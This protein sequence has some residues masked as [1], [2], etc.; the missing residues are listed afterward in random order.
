MMETGMLDGHCILVV[1]DEYLIAS[2]MTME[3][4][5]AGARVV[6]PVSDVTGGFSIIGSGRD[7]VDCAVLDVNLHGATVF[8]VADRLSGLN[9]PY[10]FLTGYHCDT[11]PERFKDVPCL[12]KP[13]DEQE[14]I[15]LLAAMPFRHG[16]CSSFRGHVRLGSE[17]EL[18]GLYAGKR[19]L[20]VEDEYFL[21]DE[22]RRKLVDLGAIV[23]GPVA[24]VEDALDLIEANA[25]DA[26]ILDVHLGDEFVFPVAERL[27]ELDVSFVFATGYDPSFIP[28]EF[29]GFS[30]C[31]KPTELGK[32]ANALWGNRNEK[33]Q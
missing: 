14:L 3:L 11:M 5:E 33:L 19:I 29:T 8:A 28:R 12:N 30:L 23:I 9:V 7:D 18:L 15:A 31:E 22:V 1:E 27:D 10:I 32:I 4:E 17:E 26:A 24:H 21:A 6:G 25:V 16:A 2:S 20:V 13:C